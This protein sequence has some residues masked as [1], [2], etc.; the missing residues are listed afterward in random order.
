[1]ARILILAVAFVLLTFGPSN[2]TYAQSTDSETTQDQLSP[3]QKLW[4]DAVAA[5]TVGPAKVKLADQ[6]TLSLDEEHIFIP[7][8]EAG[9]LMSA[10][11]N[12]YGDSFQGMIAAKAQDQYWVV[13]VDYINSGHIKDDEAK[14][15]DAGELLQSLREGTEQG[16]EYRAEIGVAQLDLKGWIEV[17]DY[18]VTSHRLVWSIEMHERGA[19]AD[20]AAVINYNTYALGR[21]GYFEL[22]LVTDGRTI[23]SDKVHARRIINGIDYEFGKSYA[24]FDATTDHVAEYGLGALVAGVA[25]KKLG[26]LALIGAFLLKGWKLLLIGGAIVAAGAGKFFRRS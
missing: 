24:D 10:W 25:A 7:R 14:T 3:A 13:T 26:L 19:P 16:N 15:W 17:P 21:T 5:A 9:K 20:Q 12:T 1:M 4:Q 6:A 11:G 2:Q 8:A 23:D 18:D 22:N